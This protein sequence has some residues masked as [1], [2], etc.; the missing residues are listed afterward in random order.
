HY[1]LLGTFRKNHPAVGA[2]VHQ[3]ISASPYVFSR[4]YTNGNFSDQVVVGL[5]LPKGKKEIA[6][7]T[8]FANGTK[9]R[10]TYSNTEATVENGKVILDT[11][12]TLVL[13]EKL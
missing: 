4:S 3:M 9:V 5:D 7:G 6:V 1:Q 11:N 8:V 12:F 13:L 10:D 2:G